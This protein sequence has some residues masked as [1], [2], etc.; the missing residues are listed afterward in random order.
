MNTKENGFVISDVLPGKL[1]ALVKNLMRLTD[2]EDP[3]EAVR[4]INS[5]EWVVSDTTA[6]CHKNNAIYL[7]VFTEDIFQ[8]KWPEVLAAKDV[9]VGDSA[10]E[11]IFSSH[12]RHTSNK[13]INLVILKDKN[14]RQTTPVRIHDVRR[15]MKYRN[16]SAPDM[17]VACYLC[18]ILR[19]HD[20][21]EM[22]LSSLLIMHDDYMDCTEHT[23]ILHIKISEGKILLSTLH[24]HRVGEKDYTGY[25]SVVS[26]VDLSS[27]KRII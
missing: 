10:K 25:V 20:L 16:F 4:R 9:R 19:V 22:G 13:M 1:N 21:Q 15:Q 12:F 27:T 2:T 17:E 7:T 6:W 11:M 5:G 8:R 24:T 3:N 18:D 14:F 23:G 26:V